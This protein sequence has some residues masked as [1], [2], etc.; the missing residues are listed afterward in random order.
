MNV[1]IR[2]PYF[3]KHDPFHSCV[4]FPCISTGI[5]GFDNAEAAQIAIIEVW[6]WLLDHPEAFDRVI[7]STFLPVDTKIYHALLD[8]AFPVNDA[9]HRSESL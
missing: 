5:F 7:F 3:S 6:R 8:A 9:S 4:A 2:G 1:W